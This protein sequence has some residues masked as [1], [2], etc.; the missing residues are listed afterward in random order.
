MVVCLASPELRSIVSL[1]VHQETPDFVNS[2]SL[3]VEVE[4]QNADGNP[5][6]NIFSPSAFH[7]FVSNGLFTVARFISVCV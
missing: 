5:V 4:Q 7:F 6:L 2:L 3:K 1:C